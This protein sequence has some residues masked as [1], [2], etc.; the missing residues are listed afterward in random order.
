QCVSCTA[1]SEYAVVSV[2]YS[3]FSSC[4]PAVCA[5]EGEY[6]IVFL[7]VLGSSRRPLTVLSLFQA[8]RTEEEHDDDPIRFVASDQWV[9]NFMTHNNLTLQKRTNVTTLSDEILVE[10]AVSYMQFLTLYKPTM[11][12]D[13]TLL[14]DETAVYFEDAR[15]D[16]VD[17][18]GS[19]HVVV[20]STGFASMRIAVML[21]VTVSGKKTPPCLIWKRKER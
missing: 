10:R 18:V 17:E 9:Q 7:L 15:T 2:E 19:R 8:S 12:R 13:R 21:V 6:S 20:H 3:I 4:K 5:T 11:N 16:T 1:G 14:M